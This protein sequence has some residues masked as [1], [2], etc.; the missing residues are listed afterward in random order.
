M[1]GGKPV[2]ATSAAIF[3]LDGTLFS[4]HVWMAVARHH[5]RRRVN[6][7][8]LYAYVALHMPLWYL[9][10]LHLISGERARYVWAQNMAWTMRGLDQAQVAAMY[11]WVAD[12]YVVPL[13]RPDVVERLRYHQDRGHRVILLSGAF[14]G[15]LA[16]VGERLGVSEVLGTRLEQRAGRYTGR[17]LPPVCQGR[18]KVERLRAYLAGPGQGIDLVASYAYADSFTDE[19]VL[20]MVGHPVAVYPDEGLASTADRKEW[21]ILRTTA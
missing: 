12:A 1:P 5:R 14:E 7:R 16:V 11:T 9:Y 3:D 2:S 19:P 8:W 17:A 13:L 21:P 4:G 6:R 18:G 10:R 15:L 20:E